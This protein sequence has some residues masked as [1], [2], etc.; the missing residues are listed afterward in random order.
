[1]ISA[2]SL[3]LPT[4][5]LFYHSKKTLKYH[6]ARKKIPFLNNEG[7]ISKPEKP[8]GIKLEMFVFDVFEY[9]E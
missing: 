4:N 1:M 5:V 3:I 2:T 9:A 8:N 6:I 7:Q